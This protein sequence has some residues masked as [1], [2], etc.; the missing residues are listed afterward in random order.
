MQLDGITLEII[1]TR[2]RE[3]GATMEH[4]LFHSGYSTILRESHDGSA[5]ITDAEGN[6]IETSG[7]P[8]N[9]LPYRMTVQSVLQRY[10]LDQMA[11]GDC[12]IS[13]DPY[14][15]G[16]LH[17]PDVIIITPIVVDGEIIGFCCSAAHK[18]DMGGLVP[19]SSG[20]AAREI[21]H[22][23]LMLPGV[24]YWSKEGV[25]PDVEAIIAR[26]CR[27]PEVIA[28]DLR[29]QVGCTLMGVRQIRAL[30][31][32]YGK[33]LIKQAFAELL[34]RTERRVREELLSW[35]DGSF[36]A[37]T[38]V[39]HDGVD[40][41]TRLRL[42]VKVTKS[43][44]HIT[45]D[46]SQANPQ[47]KGPTNLRPQSSHMAA[48]M[49]LIVTVDPAI[50]VNDGI[51]RTIT[52]VNPEGLITN[53][54]WPAP[55]NS[56]YGLAN[57]LYSTVGRALAEFKPDRAVA[58]AG[59]GLGAIAIGYEDKSTGRKAVQYDLFSSAQGGTSNHD[60]S[61]GTVGFLN[62]APSTPIEVIET[63]FPVRI[64]RFEW[65]E[66]SAGAGKFR[67]GLGNRKIYEFIQDA[68]VTVRLGHQFQFAGWGVFGGVGPRPM[69]VTLNPGADNEK[70]LH[71][72]QTLLVKEGERLMVEMA[73][74]GGYGDPL[75]R[76]PTMVADDIAN[77]F[78]SSDVARSTYGVAVHPDTLAV[79]RD[80]TSLLRRTRVAA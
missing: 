50:S 28:G 77:G 41:D 61:S 29:A 51:L 44:D 76:D 33:E 35:S 54:R 13:N 80:A 46:Y 34:D 23:G 5:A 69:R 16:T 71:P 22:E 68:T 42:H 79:D 53:P 36:E 60:G 8:L 74:G 12:F 37:E 25:N 65:I 14:G 2:L 26:N 52:F 40:L 31:G 49:A 21:F 55:V 38:F 24:R 20:A 9:L 47:V 15:G 43:G 75:E 78:V 72:L 57:V 64:E 73:G 3:I 63:E 39:D 6:T 18:P 27:I 48:L 19:G 11:D 62:K 1:D 32:D 45:F 7:G 70:A 58:S 56:Y 59:L 10:P 4:L 17:I 67:G 30:C 66:D